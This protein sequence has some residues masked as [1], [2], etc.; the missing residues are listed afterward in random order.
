M[1]EL[2]AAIQCLK[3]EQLTLY[4]RLPLMT[5]AAITHYLDRGG[6]QKPI[7]R[8]PPGTVMKTSSQATTSQEPFITPNSSAVRRTARRLSPVPHRPS[9]TSR[10]TLGPSYPSKSSTGAR[11]PSDSS[12]TRQGLSSHRER[13]KDRWR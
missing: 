6:S 11:G 13:T 8:Q 5:Q 9:I 10:S 3:T 2:K 7:R 4:Q 1:P 12:K